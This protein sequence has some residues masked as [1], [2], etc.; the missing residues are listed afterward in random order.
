MNDYDY[1][2][3]VTAMLAKLKWDTQQERR[4]RTRVTLFYKIVYGLVDIT[5]PP[6]IT[7]TGHQT[8]GHTMRFLVPTVRVDA[9]KHSFFPATIRLWNGLP[10][11]TVTASS[12]DAFRTRVG[13]L[14]LTATK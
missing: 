4:A 1:T 7:Q 3:S 12:A 6:Y 14:Q 2:S 5:F 13:A 11:E 10:S 9:Y 8:R